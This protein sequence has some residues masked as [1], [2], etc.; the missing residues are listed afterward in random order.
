MKPFVMRDARMPLVL[1]LKILW[2][3]VT[4]QVFNLSGTC[5]SFEITEDDQ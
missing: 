1:A 4:R 5:D 3:A 2:F